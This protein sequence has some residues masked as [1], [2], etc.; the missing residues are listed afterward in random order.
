MC[1][2]IALDPEELEIHCESSHPTAGVGHPD[3]EH[4]HTAPTG[5]PPLVRNQQREYH[6]NHMRCNVERRAL[7]IDGRSRDL[8]TC[9]LCGLAA[10]SLTQVASHVHTVHG[11]TSTFMCYLCNTVFNLESDLQQHLDLYHQNRKRQI[12]GSLRRRDPIRCHVCDTWY[13]DGES[14][15]SHANYCRMANHPS[16]ILI[17]GGRSNNRDY[18]RDVVRS[19]LSGNP[20]PGSYWRRQMYE[21]FQ[22]ERNHTE[23]KLGKHRD[24][25]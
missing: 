25:G 19:T 24:G 11:A 7:Q 12:Q 2:F 4:R 8:W 3:K 1:D 10:R 22:N 20:L 17:E 13:R 15:L 18:L 6:E 9:R 16:N 21:H 5:N 23:E 14:F